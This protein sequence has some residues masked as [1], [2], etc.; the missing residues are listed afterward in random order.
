MC[1]RQQSQILQSW[2]IHLHIFLNIGHIDCQYMFYLPLKISLY[3]VLLVFG[4]SKERRNGALNVTD[5]SI[6]TQ[7][8][9]IESN[10]SYLMGL[11]T[12]QSIWYGV[13]CFLGRLTSFPL[14]LKCVL[15][16]WIWI[17][18]LEYFSYNVFVSTRCD[19][20]VP[21]AFYCEMLTWYILNELWYCC[22]FLY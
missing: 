1:G 6:F 21:I 5:F 11:L 18:F 19:G 15:F 13:G 2:I 10:H 7:F 9:N 17:C 3:G 14:F 8:A 20:V 22:C 12:T 16:D 4:V